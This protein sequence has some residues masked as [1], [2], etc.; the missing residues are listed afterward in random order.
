MNDIQQ[1]LQASASKL[2][3]SMKRNEEKMTSFET[4]IKLIN[5]QLVTSINEVNELKG[6][7]VVNFDSIRQLQDKL[8]DLTVS[9]VNAPKHFEQRFNKAFKLDVNE[10]WSE[11]E[12]TSGLKT[13]EFRLFKHRAETYL[14]SG[15][16]GL[17]VMLAYAITQPEEIKISDK[18]LDGKLKHE[19]LHAD[20]T[21]L[22]E[23]D[24]I[25]FT[26]LSVMMKD[27]A[28]KDYILTN[29]AQAGMEVWRRLHQVYD[30]KNIHTVNQQIKA[31]KAMTSTACSNLSDLYHR[32]LK[33]DEMYLSLI[34]I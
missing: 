13:M 10:K 27:Q 28:V 23:L 20:I 15:P 16:K 17:D 3:E 21:N 12:V 7:D 30:P 5:A 33:L 9:G 32:M 25:L 4:T 31:I 24:V 11:G 26:E 14:K 22:A 18:T 34:H 2:V 6:K 19:R 1:G 8:K 29:K